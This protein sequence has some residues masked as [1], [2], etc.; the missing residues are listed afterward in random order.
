MRL[1]KLSFLLPALFKISY[2]YAKVQ[3]QQAYIFY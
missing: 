2:F 3:T 1:K